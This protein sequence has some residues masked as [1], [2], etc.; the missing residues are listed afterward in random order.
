MPYGRRAVVDGVP[1]AHDAASLPSIARQAAAGAPWSRSP[2]AD[3]RGSWAAFV[4]LLRVYAG[5]LGLLGDS[6]TRA[7]VAVTAG[8]S[9]RASAPAAYAALGRAID[10]AF[11][12]PP[13]LDTV[14]IG[15]F[16]AGC[17]GQPWRLE[18]ASGRIRPLATIR[19]AKPSTTS[20][21]RVPP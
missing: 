11:S 20:S 16:A 14:L 2:I 15:G 12:P 9:F 17:W 4:R 3:A 1:A 19:S 13:A 7:R 18:D 8:L 21:P 10:Q 6:A 5:A